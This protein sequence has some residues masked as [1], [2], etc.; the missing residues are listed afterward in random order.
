M[1]GIGTTTGLGPIT[2]MI[3]IGAALK[4]RPIGAL[5]R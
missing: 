1:T 2:T 4:C 5:Q 3:G